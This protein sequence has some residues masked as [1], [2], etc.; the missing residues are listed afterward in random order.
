MLIKAWMIDNSESRTITD[1]FVSEEAAQKFCDNH[2]LELFKT[3]RS[4][5]PIKF[6]NLN[7]VELNDMFWCRIND[8]K[9]QEADEILTY[10]IEQYP[11]MRTEE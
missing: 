6:E 4:N 5:K 11:D 10:I 9:Q 7:L 1:Y 8:G 2:G 3:E